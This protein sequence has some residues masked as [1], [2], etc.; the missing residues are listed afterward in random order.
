MNFRFS[1]AL[2]ACLAAHHV[3]FS[4]ISNSTSK[5]G[6][7]G[8]G[9]VDVSTLAEDFRDGSKTRW[10]GGMTANVPLIPH[11]DLQLGYAY[12]KY[13][14]RLGDV[15][16]YRTKDQIGWVGINAFMNTRGVRPF[17]ALSAARQWTSSVIVFGGERVI[18]FDA[19]ADAW[20]AKLGVEIPVRAFIVTPSIS[21]EQA[22]ESF[23]ELGH[24]DVKNYSIEIYRWLTRGV[25]GY[26]GAAYSDMQYI[27]L[28]NWLFVGGVR[29]K[30]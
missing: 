30:F 16:E 12:S 23:E 5:G 13:D 3:G 17:V 29:V 6:L 15:F 21:H 2:A 10:W 18:K 19:H 27:D 4:Q 28:S 24:Y 11:L 8:E 26:V 25:G 20:S 14:L 22:F 7:L 1:L 9:Y